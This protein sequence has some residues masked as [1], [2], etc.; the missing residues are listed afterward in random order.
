MLFE[1]YG[2]QVPQVAQEE[3]EEE[4]IAADDDDGGRNMS[5]QQE[6][7]VD[8]EGGHNIEAEDCHNVLGEGEG[9]L[10]VQEDGG[11]VQRRMTRSMAR[12][13]RVNIDY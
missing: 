3:G 5:D 6:V 4:E 2:V 13:R 12:E 10:V 9:A 11:G 1:Y 7:E 8:E